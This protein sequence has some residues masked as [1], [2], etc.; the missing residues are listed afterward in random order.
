MGNRQSED[1]SA[2][3]NADLAILCDSSTSQEQ[4][5]P[6]F[7]RLNQQFA[8]VISHEA[9]FAEELRRVFALRFEEWEGPKEVWPEAEGI[10][11]ANSVRGLIFGAALGD[12]V[13]LATEFLSRDLVLSHYGNAFD[14]R[15]GCDVYADSHRLS[16]PKGDW[17]DD[18]DQLLLILHSLLETGGHADVVD[19]ARKLTHWRDHGFPGLGDESGC[20]LGQHTKS[21][22]SHAMFAQDPLSAARAV[23]ERR[24]RQVAS[25]GAVMR[26]AVT[27][28]P[29]FWDVSTVHDNTKKMCEA[30]HADPRCTASCL[31]VA[32]SVAFLLQASSLGENGD[33]TTILKEALGYA[34]QLLSD[35]E[36]REEL[37]RHAHVN[38]LEELALDEPRTI[39]YTM[40]CLG[41]GVWALRQCN[42]ADPPDFQAVIHAIVM[43]GGDADTNAAVA[44]A[45]LG[46]YLGYSRLPERWVSAMPYAPWLEAWVQKLLHMLRLP[47]TLGRQ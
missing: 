28:V 25:N 10:R 6:A 46:C 14:F 41:A 33:V 43:Q 11:L 21:V 42:S 37:K 12:A 47:V 36:Q 30:T 22:L 29:F 17:T 35:E 13:G 31:V 23:W 15:P 4:R 32:T 38:S 18:T 44:G 9:R 19:F 3:N 1:S 5:R 7:Q 8:P 20:G 34:S 2:D 40:K 24:S 26:T 27:G 39:G 16:F 45:F